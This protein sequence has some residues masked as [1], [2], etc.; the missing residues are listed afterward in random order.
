MTRPGLRFAS[1]AVGALLAAALNAAPAL[2]QAWT[3]AAGTGTVALSYQVMKVDYHLFGGDMSPV[4]GDSNGRLDMGDITG[5]SV[6]ASASYGV[7]KNLQLSGSLAYVGATYQG[8]AAE[9]VTLDDGSFHGSFQDA[10]FGASFM[11]PWRGFAITPGMAYSFPTNNYDHHGHTAPGKGNKVFQSSVALGRGLGPWLPNAFMQ[12]A[13]THSFVEDIQEWGLDGDGYTAEL[14]YVITPKLITRGYFSYFEVK[15]GIDWYWW[16]PNPNTWH[17]HD[18]GAAV[19]TRR[20]GGAISYQFDGTKG[21][22]LDIGGILSGE[23][24]HDGV[25]YTL[26]STW[27]FLGPSFGR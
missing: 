18:A 17:F 5:Q 4:G 21:I 7:W 6:T 23:N 11:I 12:A 14:G 10:S 8:L 24:T 16:D 2:G 20:A 26:G 13:Y 3:T 15:D 27:S 19:L 9:S 1:A 25:Y 22:Y